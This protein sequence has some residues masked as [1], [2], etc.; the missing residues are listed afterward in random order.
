ML[1]RALV[2]ERGLSMRDAAR[3]LGISHQRVDQLMAEHGQWGGDERP[4]FS[5][6]LKHIDAVVDRQGFASVRVGD[7]ATEALA[8]LIEQRTRSKR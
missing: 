3:V 6:Y 7:D 4:P 2:R 5:E 1:T 8:T